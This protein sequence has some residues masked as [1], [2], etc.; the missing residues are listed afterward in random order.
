MGMSMLFSY[1]IVAVAKQQ[2]VER[3]NFE[4]L[5]VET[6]QQVA[7]TALVVT[8]PG[9]EALEVRLFGPAG[10]EIWRGPYLGADFR[11]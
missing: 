5:N 9:A 10:N 6:A 7:Q 8:Y 1:Q 4:A 2:P 11:T 3:G